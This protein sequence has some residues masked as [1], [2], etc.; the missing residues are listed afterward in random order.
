MSRREKVREGLGA[1]PLSLG[2]RL[3]M[4]EDQGALRST[5]VDTRHRDAM[6]IPLDSSSLNMIFQGFGHVLRAAGA[7]A[8]C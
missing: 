1:C 3:D 8:M 6:P 4:I 2:F 5:L 7:Q